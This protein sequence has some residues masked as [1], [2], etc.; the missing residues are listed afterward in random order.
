MLRA[1]CI[2]VIIMQWQALHI[3]TMHDNN[4][5]PAEALDAMALALGRNAFFSAAALTALDRVVPFR[6]SD[7][8]IVHVDRYSEE[9]PLLIGLQSPTG[10]YAAAIRD[11]YLTRRLPLLPVNSR[12]SQRFTLRGCIDGPVRSRPLS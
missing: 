7:A 10:Q 6:D 2:R 3:E 1:D 12:A 8:V 11:H 4:E 5:V 9:A